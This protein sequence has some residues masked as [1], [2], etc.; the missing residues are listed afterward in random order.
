MYSMRKCA[1][2]VIFNFVVVTFFVGGVGDGG[3]IRTMDK[4]QRK[5]SKMSAG[6]SFGTTGLG[7]F[8]HLDANLATFANLFGHPLE[9]CW[10]HWEP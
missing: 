8:G 3:G 6:K 1:N 9:I 7:K 2:N 4:T 10:Q 5:S